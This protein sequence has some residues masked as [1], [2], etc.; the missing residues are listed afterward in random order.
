MSF[1]KIKEQKK[2]GK[3]YT[4]EFIVKKI[5]DDLEYSNENI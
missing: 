1:E 4:P 3:V 5:L 2:L